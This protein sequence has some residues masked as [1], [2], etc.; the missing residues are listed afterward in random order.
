M[1]RPRRNDLLGVQALRAVAALIRVACHAVGQGATHGNA[2]YAAYLTH[3]FVISVA[4]ILC[5][6]IPVDWAGL[7]ATITIGFV[8]SAMVGQRTH[9]LV[10][11]P[12]LLRLRTRRPV[13]TMSAPG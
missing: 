5:R 13:S 10:E 12:L 11:Q 8:V 6:S 7:A 3:G 9:H 1:D 4:F 2:F